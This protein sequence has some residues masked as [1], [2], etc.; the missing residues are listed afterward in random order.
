LKPIY[1]DGN[2]HAR[3]KASTKF[4]PQ[5]FLYWIFLWPQGG[6]MMPPTTE[7]VI[8]KT[9]LLAISHTTDF[10]PEDGGSM[11]LCKVFRFMQHFPDIQ[12]SSKSVQQA[13]I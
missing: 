9:N 7:Q 13:E 3:S 2:E 5:T 1:E 12:L 11:F 4:S 6:F 10:D 8:R